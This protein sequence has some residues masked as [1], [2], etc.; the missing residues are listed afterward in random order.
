[1]VFI[2]FAGE[3]SQLLPCCDVARVE[4]DDTLILYGREAALD[5]LDERRADHRGGHKHRAAVERQR[6]VR[7]SQADG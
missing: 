5:D 3:V 6:Q 4:A 2:A 1:V 7:D